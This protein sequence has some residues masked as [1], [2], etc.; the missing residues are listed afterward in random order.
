MK[1]LI[2]I[3]ADHIIHMPKQTVELPEEILKVLD[4]H[5]HT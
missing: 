2:K 3:V 4:T 1:Q 5:L